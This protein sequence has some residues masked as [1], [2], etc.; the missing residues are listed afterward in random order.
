MELLAQD[1]DYK[2]EKKEWEEKAKVYHKVLSNIKSIQAQ[3][4]NPELNDKSMNPYFKFILESLVK[5]NDYSNGSHKKSK[6][7]KVR[8]NKDN[9]GNFT[10]KAFAL[11][12]IAFLMFIPI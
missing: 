5:N 2:K 1:V 8:S 9:E 6:K 4:K 11:Y 7:G 12:F 3:L 10:N